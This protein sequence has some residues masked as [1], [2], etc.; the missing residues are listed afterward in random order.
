[1][2][3]LDIYE[4]PRGLA[5]ADYQ[6]AREIIHTLMLERDAAVARAQRAET[7][8]RDARIPIPVDPADNEL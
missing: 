8:L 5:P 4:P 7:A 3:D 1:M 2:F 6:R